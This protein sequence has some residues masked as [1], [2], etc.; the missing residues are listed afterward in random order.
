MSD[1]LK[2]AKCEQFFKRKDHYEKHIN[3]ILMPCTLSCIGCHVKY[4]TKRKF[5]THIKSCV[6]YNAI[7]KAIHDNQADNNQALTNINS[8]TYDNVA[9]TTNNNT[10]HNNQLVDIKNNVVMLHPLGLTHHYMNREEVISPVKGMLVEMVRQ[11]QFKLAY[12]KLFQQIHGNPEIPEHHN[13]YA[14]E[15]DSDKVCIFNG[16]YFQMQMS[17]IIVPDMYHILKEE[18]KWA[19]NNTDLDPK[20]KDQ[21]MWDIQRDWMDTEVET[22]KTMER[23]FYNNKPVVETTFKKNK[24]YSNLE[25]IAKANKVQPEQVKWD[26]SVPLTLLN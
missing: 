25:Y 15:E 16:K 21:L 12:E 7:L 23:V 5:S 18:M 22:D 2:C 9:N 3:N 26:N 20:E 8:N 1:D 4:D 11:K 13:I 17:K 10:N 6:K 24:V 14:K 19:V